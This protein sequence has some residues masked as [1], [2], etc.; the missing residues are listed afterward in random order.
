MVAW[1]CRD[2]SV[3]N[4]LHRNRQCIAAGEEAEAGWIRILARFPEVRDIH[5]NEHVTGRIQD[6]AVVEMVELGIRNRVLQRGERRVNIL[7]R[8]LNDDNVRIVVDH[9]R[10]AGWSHS[11]RTVIAINT[12]VVPNTHFD[13]QFL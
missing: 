2:G 12:V 6:F 13:N 10:A 4:G 8:S 9:D 11:H 5:R 7:F 1:H 3:V